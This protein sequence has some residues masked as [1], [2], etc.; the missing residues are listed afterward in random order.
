M[1]EHF[2]VPKFDLPIEK[3]PLTV[4]ALRSDN[5]EEVWRHT[6][7]SPGGMTVPPLK[8]QH[9]VSVIIRIEF[10]DG[11]SSETKPHDCERDN[12]CRFGTTTYEK[13]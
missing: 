3:Y 8:K 4:M 12:S 2:G 11:T 1:T 6:M 9:G 13:E 5:R 7:M 10:G